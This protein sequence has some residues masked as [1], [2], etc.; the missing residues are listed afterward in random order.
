MSFR[1]R[2]SRVAPASRSRLGYSDAHAGFG[3]AQARIALE[4]LRHE[5]VQL[6]IAEPGPPVLARP[7]AAGPVLVEGERL[8]GERLRLALDARVARTSGKREAD[9]QQERTDLRPRHARI[10]PGLGSPGVQEGVNGG[11]VQAD[12]SHSCGGHGNFSA[13][14]RRTGSARRPQTVSARRPQAASKPAGNRTNATAVAT[15]PN[16]TMAGTAH[17][18]AKSAPSPRGAERGRAFDCG[19][20]SHHSPPC[21]S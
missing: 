13:S 21:I 18:V 6:R 12:E 8:R 9:R 3:G 5:R 1:L 4:R 10:A 7:V 2:R 15:I 14:G 20:T 17:T 11:E 19:S 16:T